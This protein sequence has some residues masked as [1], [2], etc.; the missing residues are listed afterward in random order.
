[1]G[2]PDNVTTTLAEVIDQCA[3]LRLLERIAYAEAL[4]T[5]V[6]KNGAVSPAFSAYLQAVARR[7]SLLQVLGLERR[8]RTL[9]LHDELLL[10]GKKS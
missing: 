2:G 10:E 1:M 5:G 6:V 7:A 4:K 9:S 8:Q 3:R